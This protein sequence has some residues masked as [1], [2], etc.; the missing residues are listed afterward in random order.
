MPKPIRYC[1][2]PYCDVRCYGHGLCHKHYKAFLRHGDP[3]KVVQKQHHGLT[4]KARFD[5]YTK[6]KPGCWEWIGYR[7][8]NGYGRM[9]VGDRPMLAHRVSYLVHYGSIPDGMAVL[10]KC[11]EPKCVNPEHLFLGTQADNVR[12]M[13]AKGRARKR[14]LRGSEHGMAKLDGKKVRAIRA[15]QGPLKVIAERYGITAATACDVRKR[16]TWKHI[17]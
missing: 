17:E 16:K 6:R 7:D 8:P 5:V 11:D 1:S 13:H 9:D 10:H 15:W 3:T 2:V 14:A 12:D 4:L